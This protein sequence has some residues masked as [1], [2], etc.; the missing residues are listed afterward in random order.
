M[1]MRVQ[2]V[3]L[4]SIGL[5]VGCSSSPTSPTTTSSSTSATRFFSDVLAPLG[6]SATY[7]FT[8]VATDD[9]AVTV[10][11]LTDAATGEPVQA[12]VT[13]NLGTVSGTSCSPTTATKVVAA[14][15][16][17]TIT[18][19][20]LPAGTY[21]VNVADQGEIATSADFTI[22]VVSS[23]G[24][25]PT[26]ASTTEQL[27]STLARGGATLRTFSAT[28]A[29]AASITLTS[30]TDDAPIELSLGVWDGTACRLN[31]SV[32]TASGTD[33]QI[34]TSTDAGS[35]CVRL[36]DVGNLT[37]QA[38]VTGTIQHQ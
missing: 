26:G 15:L 31:T 33:P 32:V 7:T 3:A 29:G 38:T 35:Y 14:S 20:S 9:V 5:L 19:A 37:R 2:W 28:G 25:A 12:D 4:V 34:T 18:A 24:A 21:C 22:R 6:S 8:T 11:S 23:V 36:A 16:T 10:A 30:V 27:P 17:A 1:G 13:L